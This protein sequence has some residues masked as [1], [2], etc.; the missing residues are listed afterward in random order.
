LTRSRQSDEKNI[1][2]D[3]GRLGA[4]GSL[5][6]AGFFPRVAFSLFSAALR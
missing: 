2:A 5:A 4:F 1:Y 3:R 6:F